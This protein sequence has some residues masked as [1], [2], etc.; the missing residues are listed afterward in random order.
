MT[1]NKISY[2]GK[3][4]KREYGIQ[5]VGKSDVKVSKSYLDAGQWEAAD[6]SAI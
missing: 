6:T 4:R 3:T 5:N 2:P 1:I